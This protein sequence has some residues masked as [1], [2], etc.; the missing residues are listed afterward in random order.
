MEFHDLARQF[1]QLVGAPMPPLTPDVD[2]VVTFSTSFQ[3]VDIS[4]S[5]DAAGL[6][7]HVHVLAFF[8]PVPEAI[9]T[10]VLRQALHA[11]LAMMGSSR[12]AFCR[13]PITGDIVLAATCPLGELSAADLLEGLHALVDA[14]LQWRSDPTQGDLEVR[15]SSGLVPEQ[16]LFR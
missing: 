13:N 10:L 12:C 14:A 4:V 6:P 7:D 2:G 11:N 8:G 16:L 5:H 1:C 3:D 9:E 15:P